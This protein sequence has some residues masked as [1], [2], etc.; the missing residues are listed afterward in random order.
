[1]V[2]HRP[3]PR[4]AERG[5]WSQ[6]D[7]SP[8]RRLSQ[9]HSRS[10]VAFLTEPRSPRIPVSAQDPAGTQTTRRRAGNCRMRKCLAVPDGGPV[11]CVLPPPRRIPGITENPFT[12]AR[13]I[14]NFF[15][16]PRSGGAEP[17]R[18]W[19]RTGCAAVRGGP[20]WPW[21]HRPGLL[22]SIRALAWR[23]TPSDCGQGGIPPPPGPR[24]SAAL[25]PKSPLKPMCWGRP[26]RC[27]S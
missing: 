21:P 11:P 4:G 18:M 10:R 5:R 26:S 6:G 2:S 23:R 9:Q 13:Q 14:G 17:G 24:A 16:W 22:V 20:C 27:L 25:S 12:P 1:M 15:P 3:V 8:V 7:W 19:A